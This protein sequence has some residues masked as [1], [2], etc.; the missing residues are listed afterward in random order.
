MNTPA[1][2]HALAGS[3]VRARARARGCTCRSKNATWR[4]CH[5]GLGT[6]GY[7]CL[8]NYVGH[9]KVNRAFLLYRNPRL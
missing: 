9:A 8:L 7:R 1:S 3:C 2:V 4:E 5:I 6:C